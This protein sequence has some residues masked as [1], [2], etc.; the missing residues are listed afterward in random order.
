[1]YELIA[2]THLW[3]V[4]SVICPAF[5]MRKLRHGSSLSEGTLGGIVV[6][7]SIGTRQLDQDPCS[8][9]CCSECPWEAPQCHGESVCPVSEQ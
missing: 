5:T 3:F 1:M 4:R 2:V 6:A 7:G 9:K 8:L